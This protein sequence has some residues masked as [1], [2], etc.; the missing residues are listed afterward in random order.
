MYMSVET[1]LVCGLTKNLFGKYCTS[2]NFYG[3]RRNI[4]ETENVWEPWKFFPRTSNLGSVLVLEN[5]KWAY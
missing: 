5:K 4:K 1:I 3:V 2:E